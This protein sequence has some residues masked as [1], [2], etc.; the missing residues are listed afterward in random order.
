MIYI[1]RG[2]GSSLTT[3]LP[4]LSELSLPCSKNLTHAGLT[5]LLCRTGRTLRILKLSITPLTLWGL[6]VG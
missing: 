3:S 4:R 1:F 2:I 5:D 6:E